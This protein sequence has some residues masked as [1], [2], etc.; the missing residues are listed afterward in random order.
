MG[1]WSRSGVRASYAK[2]VASVLLFG[3]NGIVA[4]CVPIASTSIVFWRTL[5][6]SLLLLAIFL[7]TRRRLTVFGNA[8]DFAYMV[9]SGVS[10]GLSWVF[11][12]EAYQLAG[13]G[14]SSVIYYLG[15]ALVMALSPV[16]FGERL[17]ARQVACFGVVFAGALMVNGAALDAGG[18]AFGLACAAASAVCHAVMVIFNKKAAS[19]Q[20][21]ENPLLQLVISFLT[22]AAYVLVAQGGHLEV[23]AA[24]WPALVF[25]GLV[26]TG[27]GCYLYFT[28][29]DGL[30]A[31]TVV[32][33]GYLEPLSAVVLAV[34]LL[35][36]PMG[37][38][39]A[40]G[41]VM[42]IGGALAAECAKGRERA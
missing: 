15:P 25:L 18:N 33:L 28:A 6:G 31:Q 36:E 13:V 1:G 12:Y 37:I 19:V 4:A 16:L 14:T 35:G 2:Y 17:G 30:R 34:V 40:A 27:L 20:G 3:S 8:R 26:N 29:L 21:L 41:A 39:Q 11:L 7:G 38:V 10:T 9:G 5:L 24:E 32:V 22:V 23:P 42:V